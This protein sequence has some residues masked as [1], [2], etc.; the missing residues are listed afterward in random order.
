V[1]VEVLRVQRNAR[2][3]K[4]KWG[5]EEVLLGAGRIRENR[6]DHWLERNDGLQGA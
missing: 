1:G 6:I 2:E 5:R 4:R 3:E